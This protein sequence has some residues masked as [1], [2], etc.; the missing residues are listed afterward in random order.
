MIL[1]SFETFWSWWFFRQDQRSWNK[2]EQTFRSKSHR[3]YHTCMPNN[4]SARQQEEQSEYRRLQEEEPWLCYWFQNLWFGDDEQTSSVWWSL[5]LH[6][7]FKPSGVYLV[8]F[9]TQSLVI[10][11]HGFVTPGGCWCC[12]GC[13]CTTFSIC[14]KGELKQDWTWSLQKCRV[15]FCKKVIRKCFQKL[16]RFFNASVWL[17]PL[18]VYLAF[19]G[20]ISEIQWPGNKL[21]PEKRG[22]Q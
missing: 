18:T 13:S 17:L 14:W 3:T 16:M 6:L 7:T 22:L 21:S 5:K 20:D 19:K 11:I 2:M 4:F 9:L 12:G 8:A 15:N 10:W 1:S